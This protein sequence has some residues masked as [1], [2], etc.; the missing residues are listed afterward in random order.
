MLQHLLPMELQITV[1]SYYVDLFIYMLHVVIVFI[2][3]I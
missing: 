1:S 2:S 3:L